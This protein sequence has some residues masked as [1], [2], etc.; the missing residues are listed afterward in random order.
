MAA[1]DLAETGVSGSPGRQTARLARL[2]DSA[3]CEGVVCSPDE[4]GVIAQV[5]PDLVRVTPGIRPI[6][7]ETHDQRRTAD[8]TEAI[9][10]GADY[11]VIGRPI[12][13]APDPVAAARAILAGMAGID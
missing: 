13:R 8:P 9:R 5:A 12:L 10:R 2:A 4:L 6:G 1:G 7:A 3:G 11:L